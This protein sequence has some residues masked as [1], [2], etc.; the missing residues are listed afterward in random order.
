MEKFAVGKN[1]I[2][3]N[4]EEQEFTQ[5]LM[6]KPIPYSLKYEF[7]IK[8]IN[9]KNGKIMIGIVNRNRIEK[10]RSYDSGMAV[11]YYGFNGWICESEYSNTYR[12]QGYGFKDGDTVTVVTELDRG[13][14]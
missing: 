7:H 12:S 10:R 3:Y 8:V 14:I 1:L 13:L 4:S 5:I 6:S 2:K 9:S 11:C